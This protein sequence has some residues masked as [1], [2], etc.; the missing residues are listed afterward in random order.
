[1][2]CSKKDNRQYGLILNYIFLYDK[3]RKSVERNYNISE[4]Q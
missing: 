2:G 4:G 3:L 1:V